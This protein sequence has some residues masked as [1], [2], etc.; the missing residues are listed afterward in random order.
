MNPYGALT[1]WCPSGASQISID[2]IPKWLADVTRD[3]LDHSICQA[4]QEGMEEQS[5]YSKGQR[6]Y[7]TKL[8]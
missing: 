8:S 2:L 4:V 7:S 5:G 3:G 1:V 6:G